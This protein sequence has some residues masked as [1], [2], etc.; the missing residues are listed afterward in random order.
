MAEKEDRLLTLLAFVGYSIEFPTQLS[1]RIGG[2]PEWNR[3]VMYRAVHEGYVSLIRKKDRRYVI[4][5]MSL[6]QKGFDYIAERNPAVL[7]MIYSR[8]SSVQKVYPSNVDKIQR[9]HAIATG[10]VAA[11]AAGA[12][13]PPSQKPSLLQ[14]TGVPTGIAVEPNTAYY[15]SPHEI[16]MAFEEADDRTVAKGSRLIGIIIKGHRCYCLY[17]AGRTRMF[18][19]R[20]TEENNAAAI[21][22]HV[23]ARGFKVKT[24]CQIVIGNSMNVA[25]KL[26]RSPNP[27]GDRYFVVSHFFDSCHF[28]TNNIEGDEL[29]N[30][31]INPER[32]VVFNRQVLADYQPPRIQTREYDAVDKNG[33]RP[34]ILNYTCDLLPL[35]MMTRVPK[36]LIMLC[37]DYQAPTL[38]IIVGASIEVRPIQRGD[39]YEQAK[40]QDRRKPCGSDP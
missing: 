1:T 9:L 2:S 29:L 17:Y 4:R 5:S 31:I 10:L 24:I 13:I 38:Q 16:R 27:F 15:Y 37:F 7:A 11:Y 3:H 14:P 8:I 33:N 32:A 20:L 25:A 35:S 12:V 23:N 18:W 36:G 40:T 30:L 34:V 21:Q 19:M 28:I 26:C 22:A 39:A 6:T